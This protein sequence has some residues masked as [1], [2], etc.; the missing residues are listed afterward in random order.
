MR[1][2]GYT[3]EGLRLL[4]DWAVRERSVIRVQVQIDVRNEASRAVA[5]RAGFHEE[6]IPRLGALHRDHHIDVV[7]YSSL[8]DDQ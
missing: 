7:M 6:G 1:G 4:A 3:T 8:R 2:C 5:V